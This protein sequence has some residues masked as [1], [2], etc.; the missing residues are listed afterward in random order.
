MLATNIEFANVNVGARTLMVTSAN[1]CRGQVDGG[2]K[3][4]RGVRPPGQARRARRP[5]PPASDGRKPVRNRSAPGSH[6]RRAGQA[7]R[8][9]RLSSRSRC[10]PVSSPHANGSRTGTARSTAWRSRARSMVLP[11]GTIPPGVGEFVGSSNVADVIEALSEQADIVLIDAPPILQV[12]DTLG[13]S[14][15]RRRAPR[16]HAP[17]RRAPLGA[18][19]AEPGAGERSGGEARSGRDRR[20]LRRELRLRLRVRLRALEF[21]RRVRQVLRSIRSA[22]ASGARAT[23]V[24]TDRRR[25]PASLAEA[26]HSA[27]LSQSELAERIGV[28]LWTVDRIESGE[29]DARAARRRDRGRDG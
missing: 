13:L 26:R 10:E 25:R 15:Q 1:R 24:C 8:W 18:R 4:R 3:P 2:G 14:A 27:G 5:G 11:V 17:L 21:G 6:R 29:A 9:K 16:R 23:R 19:R 12:G 28:P 22:E 20:L 7:S